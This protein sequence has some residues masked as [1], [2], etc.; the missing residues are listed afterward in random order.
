MSHSMELSLEQKFSIRSFE[1]QVK[2]MTQE[3]AQEF[4]VNLYEQMIL[5][6]NMYKEFIKHQWGLDSPP[7]L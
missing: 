6:D 2:N 1:T 3:Q 4:L 7:Q 5:K